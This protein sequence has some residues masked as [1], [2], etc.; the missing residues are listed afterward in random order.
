[1]QKIATKIFRIEP[2]NHSDVSTKFFINNLIT[3]HNSDS[4]NNYYQLIEC[5]IKPEVFELA[6]YIHNPKTQKPSWYGLLTEISGN[7]SDVKRIDSK[8]PSFILFFYSGN[9]IFVITGGGGYRVIESALD[10]QFGFKV[11]ERLIDPSKD[12]LRGL[13]QR[14]FLGA[15]LASNRFFKADYVFA[16]ED[17]FGKYYR[18]LDV[19]V[20]SEKLA[21][22]GVDTNKKKLLIKGEL[23]FKIDTKI[24]FDELLNR[25]LKISD[26]L[27]EKSIIELNPFKRLTRWELKK[28][29]R[30]E[31]TL[32][33]L[34]N[35][36]LAN[37]FFNEYLS[38]DAKEIYHPNLMEFLNCSTICVRLD[39]KEIP[40]PTS[41]RITPRLIFGYLDID[42]KDVLFP[43][44]RE[45]IEKIE[46]WIM[47]EEHNQKNYS[48]KLCDWFY[49]EVSDGKDQYLKF[50][51][52]WF[53]YS[54]RFS[55]DINERIDLSFER[56][57][58]YPMDIWL[59]EYSSEAI[60]NDSFS[61]KENFIVGDGV[62]HN[63]IEIADL[64]SWNE[65][66]LLIFHVKDGLGRNLR[67]LQS[68]IINSAKV[69]ASFQSGDNIDNIR[70]YHTDLEKA[71][72]KSNV[73]IPDFDKFLEIFSNKNVRFIFAVATD[74]VN[75][76][77]N[78]VL[79][80]IKDSRSLIA[81]IAILHSY[82]SIKN[83]D[84]NFSISKIVKE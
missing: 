69:I 62:F 55:T 6:L 51:N 8:Y 35:Q 19:F 31:K 54:A 53:N 22:I 12:D 70:A 59:S 38:A 10:S 36:T 37:D 60:Y 14:V 26:L 43:R 66:E 2:T 41:Q 47:D 68:Q 25:I 20:S 13:S 63:G 78:D 17:T 11:V 33:D 74:S 71:N 52:E 72:L 77:K 27:K 57:D 9:E 40:I 23:G 46:I 29:V 24:S 50:E 65:K 4:T 30:K 44:F 48:S 39:K 75:T 49:G 5:K 18:G 7:N 79:K 34:L 76:E 42:D 32:E 15:E 84:Y 82:Y 56:I 67:V 81:K 80:E 61:G 16:D 58:I 64:I 73:Q 1:M 28:V 83:L 21:S 3:L 45:L